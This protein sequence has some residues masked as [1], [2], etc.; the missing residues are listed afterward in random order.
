MRR[1]TN[2]RILAVEA[3]EERF[4]LA[5]N[6]R[7]AIRGGD[8]ILRGDVRDNQMV[9]TQPA[10]GMLRI[11]GLEGTTINAQGFFDVRSRF[12]DVVIGLQQGGEDQITILGPMNAPGDL[13]VRL[14]GGTFLLDG[15][16]GP[17]RIG[18]DLGIRS[19]PNGDVTIRNEVRFVGDTSIG[20]GGSAHVVAG[21]AALP[22]FRAARFSNSLNI[23]NPC[24]PLVAGTTY[25]YEVV[26]LDEAGGEVVTE[27][28]VV[29]V[30]PATR[31][32]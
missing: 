20:A 26:E 16:S 4:L 31:T 9:L 32:I 29:E 1:R 12:D 21:K 3:L 28:I 25:T 8:L 24:F 23:N 27:R 2:R 11:T 22:D 6:V 30:L 14:G 5:G 17:V 7:A 13:R 15:S 19:R 18:Q 10:A